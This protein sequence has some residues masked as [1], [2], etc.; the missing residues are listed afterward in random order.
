MNKLK[1]REILENITGFKNSHRDFNPMFSIKIKN[2]KLKNMNVQKICEKIINENE[3]Y[4]C[5]QVK[6]RLL[7][8]LEKE[9]QKERKCCMHCRGSLF[10]NSNYC[11]YCGRKIN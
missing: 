5:N 11:T 10:D 3:F 2:L 1:T 6:T 9:V 7:D 8:L 4:S